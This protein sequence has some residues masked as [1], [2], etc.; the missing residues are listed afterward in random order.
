MVRLNKFEKY[1]P[2]I[3][4]P[5]EINWQPRA[6]HPQET[7]YLSQADEVFFGGRAGAGKVIC[8]LG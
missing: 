4:P 1:A 3:N 2:V 8:S 6:G 7:A 5:L